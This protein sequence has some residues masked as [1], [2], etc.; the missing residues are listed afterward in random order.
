MLTLL[1]PMFSELLQSGTRVPRGGD[2][3]EV[4]P[5]PPVRPTALSLAISKSNT[6]FYSGEESGQIIP[7]SRDFYRLDLITANL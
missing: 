4:V 3:W 7:G 2:T 5:K 1:F 6:R